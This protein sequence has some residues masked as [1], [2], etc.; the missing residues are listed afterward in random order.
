[1]LRTIGS[2]GNAKVKLAWDIDQ[3]KQVAI[4]VMKNNDATED[5]INEV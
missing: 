4:K 1:V 3:G 2:G 5:I